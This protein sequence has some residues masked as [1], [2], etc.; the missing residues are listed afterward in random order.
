[1]FILALSD[2]SYGLSWPER[3]LLTMAPPDN[4]QHV[5]VRLASLRITG[6]KRQLLDLLGGLDPTSSSSSRSVALVVELAE[7]RVR[8]VLSL[9]SFVEIFN[10]HDL[11]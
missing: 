7:E 10:G 6:T 4:I 5:N 9:R 1:M 8:Q 11:E 2:L 3:D